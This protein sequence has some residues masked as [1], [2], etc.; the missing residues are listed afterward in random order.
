VMARRLKAAG[1]A[2]VMPAGSPIGSGQGLLMLSIVANRV[3][4]SIGWHGDPVDSDTALGRMTRVSRE[5]ANGGSVFVFSAAVSAGFPMV[6][7]ARVGWASRHPA[8]LFL[9]GCYPRSS[10]TDQTI[11]IHRPDQMGEG[12]R[13]LFVG[14]IDQLLTDQPTLLFVDD[15]EIKPAFE[16]RRFDYLA[17]Y[18]QDP[19]FTDFLASYEPFTRVDQFLVYRRKRRNDR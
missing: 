13:F 8:L 11:A 4:E 18:E 14:I 12:E 19:R 1:A 5:H 3:K 16:A 9:P 10:Q 17:Y 7:Y 2:S 15:S 6:N